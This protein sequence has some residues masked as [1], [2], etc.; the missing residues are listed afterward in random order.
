MSAGTIAASLI[1]IDL[2]EP[3][4]VRASLVRT[5]SLR[6]EAAGVAEKLGVLVTVSLT[7]VAGIRARAAL[8]TAGLG[9]AKH[10]RTRCRRHPTATH[11]GTSGLASLSS[12]N[13]STA[14][15]GS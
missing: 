1:G 7:H 5:P 14:R 6:G 4:R 9:S 8:N 3:D 13:S 10:V 12:T 11:P 2:V 15:S